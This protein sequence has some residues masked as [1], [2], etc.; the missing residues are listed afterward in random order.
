M[1][2]LTG[3][4]CFWREKKVVCCHHH[5]EKKRYRMTGVSATG[6]LIP[7]EIQRTDKKKMMKKQQERKKIVSGSICIL[8]VLFCQRRKRSQINDMKLMWE[9][10]EDSIRPA[11]QRCNCYCFYS[12]SYSYSTIDVTPTSTPTPHKQRS[13]QQTETQLWV[14][15]W[16]QQDNNLFDTN[17]TDG[18]TMISMCMIWWTS[19]HIQ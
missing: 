7:Y 16:R 18:D 19:C 6:S 5:H 11:K 12:Y 1:L 2:H 3:D 4:K 9:E 10:I 15:T 13:I 8:L 17:P 14:S